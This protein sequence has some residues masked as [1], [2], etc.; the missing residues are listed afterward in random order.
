MNRFRER[1][2]SENIVDGLPR[3]ESMGGPISISELLLWLLSAVA[4]G[5]ALGPQIQPWLHCYPKVLHLSLAVLLIEKIMCGKGFECRF[6]F[7]DRVVSQ[8]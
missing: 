1:A 4:H 7:A 5:R 8:L 6:G 2:T 3:L